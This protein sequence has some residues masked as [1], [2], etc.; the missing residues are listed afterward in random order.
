[1]LSPL[2]FFL[3]YFF[4]SLVSHPYAWGMW[5]ECNYVC[6]DNNK[7]DNRTNASSREACVYCASVIRQSREASCTG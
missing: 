4:Y 7:Q 6:D 5:L 3:F 1:M 2:S